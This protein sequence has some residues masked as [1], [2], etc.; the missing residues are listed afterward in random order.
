MADPKLSPLQRE[1]LEALA[2]RW[3]VIRWRCTDGRWRWHAG[4]GEI[5][6][7]SVDGLLRRALVESSAVGLPRLALTESG[8][9]V[10][11]ERRA[12]GR[13]E[14]GGEAR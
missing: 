6:G 5:D 10:V 2:D 11:R 3:E 9:A 4:E 14:T 12:P 8:R 7:R 13:P 1:I